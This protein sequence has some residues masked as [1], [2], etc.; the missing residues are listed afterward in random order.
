MSEHWEV[1]SLVGRSAGTRG[2]LQSLGGEHNQQ[3]V[4]GKAERAP[5]SQLVPLPGTP[6]P[7]AVLHWGGCGLGA[8]AQASEVRTGEK[9][10]GGCLRGLGCGVPPLREEAWAPQRGRAPLLG[11]GA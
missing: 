8:E 6:Q 10:G 4:E 3:F 1:P 9:T 5:Q 2:E 11:W 7:E